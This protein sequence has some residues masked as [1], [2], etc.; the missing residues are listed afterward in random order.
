MPLLCVNR[1]GQRQFTFGLNLS[2][3]ESCSGLNG[4][5]R[6]IACLELPA[7]LF[8]KERFRSGDAI[9]FSSTFLTHCRAYCVEWNGPWV[10]AGK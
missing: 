6:N 7:K 9:E 2:D 5:M 10:L 8:G 1:S 4:N 3:I